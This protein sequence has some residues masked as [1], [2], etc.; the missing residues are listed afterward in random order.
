MLIY[1]Y[2]K[3]ILKNHSYERHNNLF[4]NFTLSLHLMHMYYLMFYC[5][6]LKMSLS[7]TNSQFQILFL[8][9]PI[10]FL[11]FLQEDFLPKLVYWY[12]T[13][14]LN[15]YSRNNFFMFL[16]QNVLSCMVLMDNFDNLK[17]YTLNTFSKSKQF[18]C[19]N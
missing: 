17:Y 5:H 15:G 10:I 13:L 9:I 19:F 18:Q 12:I 7:I 6:I 3:F 16:L 14:L 1:P 2:S 11:K 4:L 8:V